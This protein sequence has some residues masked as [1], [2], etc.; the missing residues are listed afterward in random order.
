M[1]RLPEAVAMAFKPDYGLRLQKDGIGPQVEQYFYS[2]PLHGFDVTGFGQFTVCL[3]VPYAGET[4]ALSLDFKR[5]HLAAILSLLP[6]SVRQNIL[7]GLDQ[8][9][10]TPRS[11]QFPTAVHCD[12]ICATLG[13]IQHGPYENYIPLNIMAVEVG[14]RSDLE[15]ITEIP[16]QISRPRPKGPRWLRR[17]SFLR[18]Q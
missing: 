7:L 17:F 13:Q 4:H 1:L 8:D 9:P 11:V 3:D 14:S 6:P 2:V 16:A 12:W 18:R 10:N 15:G 5:E